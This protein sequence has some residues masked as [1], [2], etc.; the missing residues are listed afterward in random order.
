MG[1]SLLQF[2]TRIITQTR[3]PR[4]F[5]HTF[6]FLCTPFS[7]YAHLSVFMHTFQ[8]LCTPFSF[9][10]HLSVFMHTFQ[11]LCTP[12]SFYA[13]LSVFMHTFQFLC[14]PFSF[15]AHFSLPLNH[16]SNR[17]TVN[18]MTAVGLMCRLLSDNVSSLLFSIDN[19][20]CVLITNIDKLDYYL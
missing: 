7:F 15:Y 4:V 18:P 3:F 16:Y 19:W 2:T 9:Y 10:A 6:Q 12:F 17:Q 20:L 5:M 8:F 14:T 1:L 11:F 13:H